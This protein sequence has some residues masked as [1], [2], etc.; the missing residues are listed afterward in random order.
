MSAPN[1]QLPGYVKQLVNAGK[2]EIG[3]AEKTVKKAHADKISV[4]EWLFHQ[5]LVS[6]K[7][8]A[9][10]ASNEYGISVVDLDAID[11]R[12]TV[13]D[14]IS[15]EQKQRLH[16]LPIYRYGNHLIVALADPIYLPNLDDVKFATNLRPEPVFVEFDKLQIYLANGGG[17]NGSASP[18][19]S[20]MAVSSEAITQNIALDTRDIK[21]QE[22]E[23]EEVEIISFVDK[24]LAHAI[25]SKVSDIHIEP[26]EKNLR[27]RYRVDGILKVIATPPI[28]I[29]S[30]L[31][32]RLKVLARMNISER[33]VPQD[34]RIRFALNEKKNIDF[35]V[36][37]LPTIY[38]EKVVMRILDS[39]SATIGVEKLGFDPK[40]QAD[41]VNALNKPDGMVLVTGPTGSGKTVT[42]YTGLGMLNT[43][44]TNISTAEDPAEINMPGVNQVNVN[45]KV[46]LT[47][48]EALRAFLRQDPDIIMVGEIRDLETAEISIKAAQTGHLV[49]STLHTNSAPETLT[50]L[51]NMGVPPFNIASSVHLIIAQRLA[52]R[53]C[54]KC[55]Q[56]SNVPVDILRSFGFKEEEI[57]KFIVYEAIGCSACSQGYKGRVGIY[58]VMPISPAMGRMV[59]DGCNSMDLADQAQ[60]ENILDL[61]QS[62]LTK[63]KQGIT[64]LAE[65]ERVTKD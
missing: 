37:T 57:G 46:G 56:P 5:Q 31:T 4:M 48:A 64:S 47:F 28:G 33:R 22:A 54:E 41:F 35:R 13:I 40:Q 61:R 1:I 42:L 51:L 27:I 50:R 45:P 29:A 62:G 63:V 38:G 39:D 60:K 14:L 24:L 26:Y 43:P 20:G 11:I 58:Q 19:Q 59:M 53:L 6:A 9:R 44:E 3:V 17:F 32:S 25:N 55:K 10:A 23:G 18:M 34:G 8:L 12:P 2:L 21:K 16:L 52:R 36:N 30:Q 49:L 65:I 7:D 15:D